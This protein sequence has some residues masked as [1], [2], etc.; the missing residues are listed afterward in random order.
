VLDH[1][2]STRQPAAK[3]AE[4]FGVSPFTLYQWRKAIRGP[5]GYPEWAADLAAENAR[6]REELAVVKEQR[7]ILKK[8][9]GIL[10]E[11]P[12][13]SMPASKR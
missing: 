10:C 1:W 8:S 3:V 11:P 4:A 12:R 13:R 7:D 2:D 5:H 6:L 9:L